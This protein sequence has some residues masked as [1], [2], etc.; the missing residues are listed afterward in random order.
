MKI[1]RYRRAVIVTKRAE[2]GASVSRRQE[3]GQPHW[4]PHTS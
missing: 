3:R 1:N 4:A 2:L